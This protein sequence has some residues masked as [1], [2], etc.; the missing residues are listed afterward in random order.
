MF[1][2]RPLV[3]DGWVEED[4]FRGLDDLQITVL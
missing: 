1:S 3:T 4:S 2:T